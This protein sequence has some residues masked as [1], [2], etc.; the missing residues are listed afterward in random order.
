MIEGVIYWL[1]MKCVME[2][3]IEMYI[4]IFEGGLK[5]KFCVNEI[6]IGGLCEVWVL[7]LEFCC[8]CWVIVNLNWEF[9]NECLYGMNRF[10][11]I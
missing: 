3:G 2:N 11:E 8:N 5:D 4:C 1:I 6:I 10:V 9:E 7:L